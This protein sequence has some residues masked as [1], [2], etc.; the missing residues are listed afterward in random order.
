MFKECVYFLFLF[1]ITP[2]TSTSTT[3]EG[4]MSVLANVCVWS[5]SPDTHVKN[6]RGYVL[7]PCLGGCGLCPSPLLY[8]LRV[9]TQQVF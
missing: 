7:K 6:N 3:R 1:L 9:K 4:E 2:S 5:S 8:G